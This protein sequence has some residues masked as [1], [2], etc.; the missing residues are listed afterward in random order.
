MGQKETTGGGILS[1][2]IFIGQDFCM[3]A[4]RALK[5]AFG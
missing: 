2:E 3:K 1:M 4:M 5:L